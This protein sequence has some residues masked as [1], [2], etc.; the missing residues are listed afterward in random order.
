MAA[1][2]MAKEV[3]D[4]QSEVKKRLEKTSTKYKIVMDKHWCSKVFGM[5]DL[6]VIFYA[7]S[8]F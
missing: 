5:D 8:V 7:M 1:E 3:P 4:V 2:H 6:V